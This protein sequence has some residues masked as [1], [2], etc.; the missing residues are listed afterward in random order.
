MQR[1][2]APKWAGQRMVVNDALVEF[3]GQ[4]VCIGIVRY[5]GGP[6]LRE[7]EPLREQDL[8]VLGQL[9][10]ITL[11]PVPDQDLS[12]IHPPGGAVEPAEPEQH[13]IESPG[14]IPEPEPEPEPPKQ[15]RKPGPKPGSKRKPRASKSEPTDETTEADE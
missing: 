11:G 3:D 10:G 14:A 13:T 8:G 4:G 1:V 9:N 6:V 5:G 15:R 7:P 2:E 12:G